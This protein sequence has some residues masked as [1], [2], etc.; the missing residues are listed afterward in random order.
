MPTKRF[1]FVL[2]STLL[3]TCFTTAQV[4]LER[5]FANPVISST[6]NSVNYALQFDGNNDFVDINSSPSLDMSNAVTMEAWVFHSGTGFG[7]DYDVIMDRGGEYEV[8]VHKNREV[9]F[10]INTNSPGWVWINSGYFLP[11][12]I[13]THIAVTYSAT[14]QQMKLYVNGIQKFVRSANGNIIKYHEMDHLV[15]GNW[16]VLTSGFKGI[17]DEVRLWNSALDSAT[18]QEWMS[19]SI[20]SIHPNYVNLKGYWGFNEG[21]G[22]TTADASGNGN[23]GTLVNG[24]QWINLS[25]DSNIVAYYPF[26]GNANDA[27]GNNNHGLIAGSVNLTKDRFGYT[28]SAYDFTNTAS[29][30]NLPNNLIARED[31][32]SLSLWFKTDNQGVIFGSQSSA[33]P[34]WPPHAYVPNIYIGSDSRLRA[35]FWIGDDTPITSSDTVNDNKWHFVVLSANVDSQSLYLDGNLIGTLAG[36]IDNSDA[37]YNQI[38]IGNTGVRNNLGW[39]GGNDEWYQY[40][41]KIDDIRIHNYALAQSEIDSFFREGGWDENFVVGPELV[42]P[43]DNTSINSTFVPFFWRKGAADVTGYWFELASDSNFYFKSIDTSL[44]DTMKTMTLLSVNT[45]YWWRVRSKILS[46]WSG[47]SE[48]RK[49]YITLTGIIENGNLPAEFKLEQNYPNPFNPTTMIKYDLPVESNVKLKV[50]DVLGREI[51]TLIDGV[52]TPGFK[53][54]NWN[55][56]DKFGRNLASGIYFYKLEATSLNDHQKYF[57]QIRKMI[58]MR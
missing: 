15:V 55:S 56:Q 33:Y 48:K 36:N 32:L 45:K 37:P 28:N 2:I 21:T 53:S 10:A 42:Y 30:I 34:S 12:N 20:T 58:L 27:S 31:K 29:Y 26:N 1:L 8:A 51:V 39:P 16:T 19:K 35:E 23:T 49:F 47:F 3:L 40:F 13:W 43:P 46:G 22:L 18:I 5:Y 25:N 41:G 7:S 52:Q 50:F 44:T 4:N 14:S 17:I 54:I 57:T 24:P 38:G 6:L 9:N 11:D